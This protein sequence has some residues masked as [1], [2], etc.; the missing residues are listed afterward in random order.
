MNRSIIYTQEQPRTFDIL[1]GWR[2]ALIAAGYLQQDLAGNTTTVVT[3]FAATP[4]SPASLD[5]QISQDFIA[6]Q[7]F[8]TEYTHKYVLNPK[9]EKGELDTHLRLLD[10]QPVGAGESISTAS[11]AG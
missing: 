11:G 9:S 8:V 7:Y 1:N 2:D 4:S 10:R 3:G 6:H 5:G